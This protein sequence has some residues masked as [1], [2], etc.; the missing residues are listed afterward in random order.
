MKEIRIIGTEL[1]KVANSNLFHNAYSND[2]EVNDC[3]Q[4]LLNKEQQA[5]YDNGGVAIGVRDT[6]YSKVR[7]AKVNG[8]MC[9]AIMS[10]AAYTKVNP[11]LNESNELNLTKEETEECFKN[12]SVDVFRSSGAKDTSGRVLTREEQIKSGCARMISVVCTLKEGAK[13]GSTNKLDYDWLI[14]KDNATRFEPIK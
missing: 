5:I 11:Y 6:D 4:V 1:N 3:M 14:I 9:I 2:K 8:Q 13:E 10:G 7:V 12:G